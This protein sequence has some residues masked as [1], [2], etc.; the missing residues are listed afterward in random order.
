MI[1]LSISSLGW[2]FIL[3]ILLSIL[4]THNLDEGAR[5]LKLWFHRLA[6]PY[7][8]GFRAYVFRNYQPKHLWI[9]H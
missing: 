1:L 6:D 3:A 5:L 7:F 9:L 2:A 4:L 8:N